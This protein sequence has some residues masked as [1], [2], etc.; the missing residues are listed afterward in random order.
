MSSPGERLRQVISSSGPI[1]FAS[2][3]EEALYGEGGY[4]TRSDL[5]IGRDGDFVTGSSY[6]PLFGEATAR[7]LRRLDGVLGR[8]ADFLEAGYGSGVHLRAVLATMGGEDPR[9]VWGWDRRPR[10]LPAPARSIGRLDEIGEQVVDGLIFSYELFDALPVH[11][12][13]RR[14][15][16]LGELWVDLGEDDSFRFVEGEL[17]EPALS[18]LLP[19]G[20][21]SLE[22]GQIADLAPGWQPL[23]RQLAERLGRGLLVTFDY[24]FECERLLDSRVRYLGTLACYRHQRVHRDPFIQVGEQDLTAHVDF[25]SLR[26]AGEQLG[27]ETIAFTPQARWL[28]ASGIFEGLA[29]AEPER[30]L[31]AMTLLDPGGMGE[32]IR[33]LVQGRGVDPGELFDL[34]TLTG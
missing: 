12:L 30:R 23:Y 18:R 27:L 15:V 31:E 11:R 6:S 33:V 19:D 2:F 3:M 14:Q 5:A 29:G 4:Y 8:P 17:S 16:G 28:G 21:N 20:G 1:P 25:S 9:R 7:I 13:I 22:P 32:E 34:E 10:S 24:G 26:T